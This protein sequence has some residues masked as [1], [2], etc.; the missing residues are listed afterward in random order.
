M[1][2]KKRRKI[3]KG[4]M[5]VWIAPSLTAISLPGHA[6]TS[7]C[8]SPPLP[9]PPLTDITISDNG[10]SPIDP[11]DL[12]DSGACSGHVPACSNYTASGLPPS[13]SM[14]SSGVV[15]GAYDAS[16]TE[17]FLIEVY[18]TRCEENTLVGG[19]VLTISDDG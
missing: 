7:S 12:S 11:I 2:E 5:G 16:G 10:G 9:P 19:F 4:A 15:S 18:A 1:S 14:S 6:Q 3:L 17:S 8:F 13:L